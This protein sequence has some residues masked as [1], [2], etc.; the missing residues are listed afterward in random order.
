[1]FA[2]PVSLER[3]AAGAGC[4]ANVMISMATDDNMGPWVG[5]AK[6]TNY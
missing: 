5:S 1:M 2:S 4:S 6:L 3:A